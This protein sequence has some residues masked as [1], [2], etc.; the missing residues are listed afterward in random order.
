MGSGSDY[1]AAA[2]GTVDVLGAGGAWVELDVSDL[3][4]AWVAD[5]A[6]NHGLVLLQEAASGSVVYDFC[7][8]L[9]WSPCSAAQAPELIVWYRQ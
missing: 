7:S 3:A 6:N 4:Q 5:P 1:L 9:G 2:D 8:E